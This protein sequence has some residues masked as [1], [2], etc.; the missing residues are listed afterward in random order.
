ME[1]V[2]AEMIAE[3]V[4][5]VCRHYILSVLHVAVRVHQQQGVMHVLGWLCSAIAG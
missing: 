1:T 5:F 3:N 4:F 2:S